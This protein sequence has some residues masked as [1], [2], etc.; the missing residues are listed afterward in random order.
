MAWFG[1]AERPVLVERPLIL[2][3]NV[4]SGRAAIPGEAR[5]VGGTP[6]GDGGDHLSSTS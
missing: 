3:R 4:Q 1:R 6:R 5:V 2:V